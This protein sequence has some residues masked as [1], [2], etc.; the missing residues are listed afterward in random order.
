MKIGEEYVDVYQLV[1]DLLTDYND[2]FIGCP[3][4]EIVEEV[5]ECIDPSIGIDELVDHILEI[6]DRLFG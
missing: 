6:V 4:S 3:D 1:R 2:N 5:V